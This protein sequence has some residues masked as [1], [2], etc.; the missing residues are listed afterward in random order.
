MHPWSIRLSIFL[1]NFSPYILS[2][3][4]GSILV[5]IDDE[6]SFPESASWDLVESFGSGVKLLG[7]GRGIFGS[8]SA[9]MGVI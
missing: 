3:L 7:F 5:S 9:R 2:M 6:I 1:S 4:S 8:C